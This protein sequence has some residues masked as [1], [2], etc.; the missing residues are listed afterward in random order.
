M[1]K[2]GYSLETICFFPINIQNVH[3]I[4]CIAEINSKNILYDFL[5]L[6]G[7]L[8]IIM[9]RNKKTKLQM[10]FLCV[11][12]S[13][14]SLLQEMERHRFASNGD[15]A[16]ILLLGEQLIFAVSRSLKPEK[17][18]YSAIEREL[19]AVCYSVE[20]LARFF[21]V[22]TDHTPHL[23]WLI[24]WQGNGTRKW[25]KKEASGCLTQ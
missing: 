14:G 5:I 25:G 16:G 1:K 24:G 9:N 13:S 6:I 4:I 20:R 19:L 2:Q 11:Y 7:N 12:S 17:Q 22:R 10:I 18:R 15:I 8:S 3:W 23:F 21:T